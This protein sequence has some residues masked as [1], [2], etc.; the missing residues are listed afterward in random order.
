[1]PKAAKRPGLTQALAIMKDPEK[2]HVLLGYYLARRVA[3]Y[4]DHLALLDKIKLAR[5][6]CLKQKNHD[7]LTVFAVMHSELV[8]PSGRNQESIA[9]FK[10]HLPK[11]FLLYDKI[12]YATSE[13]KS[14]F[15]T[16][17]VSQGTLHIRRHDFTT[18]CR[19]VDDD[20]EA[21][22][23]AIVAGSKELPL[24]LLLKSAGVKADG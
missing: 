8:E 5:S 18:V 11:E 7:L 13:T 4:H 22:S 10:A 20:Y 23:S 1:M 2:F 14:P 19:A 12:V 24:Y 15:V 21:W 9:F 3:A 16:H 6:N 17:G